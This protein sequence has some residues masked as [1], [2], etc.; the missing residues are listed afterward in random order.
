MFLECT[1]ASYV[2]K[3]GRQKNHCYLCTPD[4]ACQHCKHVLVRD[5]SHCYPYCF[6]CYCVLHPDEPRTRR[7][8]LKE[9][10]VVDALRAHF[11]DSLT[12]THDRR[13]DGGCT[14]YRPDI[15]VDFGSHCLIVEIDEFRHANYT[16]EQKRETDL[17]EDLGFCNLVFLRFNPDGYSLDGIRHPTPFQYGSDGEM[18]VDEVEMEKRIE[19]LIQTILYV[20]ENEPT[21]PL[22]HHYL[23]YGDTQ[24][25]E[26]EDND[27]E[28]EKDP[29]RGI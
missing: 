12:M 8:R 10:Y 3:H 14:R 13:I 20:K 9:H 23:F 24:E 29:E 1:D 6:R 17:Y 2:C 19:H 11:G 7:Y 5:K 26:E 27:D 16:C 21:E 4:S 22:S 25:E 18:K 28:D 15:L